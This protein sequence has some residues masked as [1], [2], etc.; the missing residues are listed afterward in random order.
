MTDFQTLGAKYAEER[1]KRM[2]HSRGQ[3]QYINARDD[4]IKD[5]ADDPWVDYDALA[6]A[7][8][9]FE[10]GDSV[11]FFIVGTG[12]NGVMYAV[13]LVEAGFKASDI[14]F[15]DTSGGFGGTWYWNRYP[16]VMCD[17]EGFSYVP[18]LEETGY[19][20]RHQF[21]QGFEIR[22]QIERITQKWKFAD[23]A[24]FCTKADSMVY[25]EAEGRWT[26]EMTRSL[27]P[28]HGESRLTVSAQF[29]LVAGGV[30]NVPKVPAHAAFQDFRKNA[31]VFHTS[32]WDYGVTG[33]CQE[34]PDLDKLQGKTVAIIGTGATSIQAVPELA[35][36]AKHLYVVQRTPSYVGNRV[37]PETTPESWAK[38]A[39]EPGWQ[40][41][42]RRNY[43]SFISNHPEPGSVNLVNDGWSNTPG[44]SGFI[45]NP[46]F[47][48][49]EPEKVREHIEALNRIDQPRTD[50]VRA[51]IASIVKDPNVAE[52]LKPWYNS[53][54]KRPA[55]HDQYLQTFNRPNVT[56]LDTNGRGIDGYTP[57]GLLVNG[58]EY[59]VDV[60]VMAT[61]FLLPVDPSGRT[62]APV[63]G[64]GGRTV[65]EFFTPTNPDFGTL[66]AVA[67]PG[68]PNMF[69]SSTPTG[70]ASYN[71]TH[72]ADVTARL[73]SHVIA[74]GSRKATNPDTLVVEATA[75]AA[76][77]YTQEVARQAAWFAVM[78]TC[79][80][81]YFTLEGE[82]SK[83]TSPE[84]A[85]KM[86][87]MS[88]WGA[89][90]NDW[91]DKVEKYMAQGNL[92]GWSIC[93]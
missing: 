81:G 15:V 52:K 9:P 38:V 25:N 82:I 6:A 43:N 91:Q 70:G 49:P 17:I 65:A 21:S 50:E 5:L 41:R 88:A 28:Q 14:C 42:R 13:H 4:S 86:A 87:R 71:Y 53:W 33:G 19:M 30:L 40:D 48:S 7:N 20:P 89:G 45:G 61:G 23:R 29:L 59:Q 78:P 77:R 18:L 36:W 24:M 46:Q 12:I 84:Q 90:M 62:G 79:T 51:H 47:I 11:K 39:T 76:E 55:F 35:K 34:K 83:P 73:I 16:G 44:A 93:G 67:M 80:P 56:L 92:E 60:L 57:H 37:N 27:G 22:E 3:A 63:V 66:L 26:I 75:E 68:F 31:A 58:A 64:R 74:E 32:R 72:F 69:I 54:C 1:E 2:R 8:P 85:A 10:D